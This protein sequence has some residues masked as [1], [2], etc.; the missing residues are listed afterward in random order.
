[1]A[2]TN[3]YRMKFEHIDQIYSLFLR[4]YSAT[5]F[6]RVANLMLL[7]QKLF[8]F[9]VIRVYSMSARATRICLSVSD[10]VL[11][12]PFRAF[13]IGPS[14]FFLFLVRMGRVGQFLFYVSL[15]NGRDRSTNSD[16]FSYV[17]FLAM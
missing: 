2:R 11:S 1:M 17:P 3:Q 5:K 14:N 10:Q 8:P 7:Q 9:N 4:V 16:H 12:F 6:P 15:L 13:S